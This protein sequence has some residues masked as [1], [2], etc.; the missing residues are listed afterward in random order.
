MILE[1]HG[2]FLLDYAYN[3]IILNTV[4]LIGVQVQYSVSLDS[5]AGLPSWLTLLQSDN[6]DASS[7][8]FLYGTPEESDLGQITLNVS[9][10][11]IKHVCWFLKCPALDY[12]PCMQ[13]LFSIIMLKIRENLK[14]QWGSRE[15]E[16]WTGIN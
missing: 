3:I 7:P 16:R 10:L 12:S 15:R 6:Q 14:Q 4:F 2:N 13:R 8:A 9:I 11:K 1:S 5:A